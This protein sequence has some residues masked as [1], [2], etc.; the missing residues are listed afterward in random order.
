MNRQDNVFYDP[1][2]DSIRMLRRV[3]SFWI[4]ERLEDHYKET[5]S[6]FHVRI[7]S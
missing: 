4:F 6:S 2:M 3:G 1:D 7:C 5:H